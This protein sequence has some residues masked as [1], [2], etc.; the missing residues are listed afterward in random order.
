MSSAPFRIECE[1]ASALCFVDCS[2]R[3]SREKITTE[4]AFKLD[5][6]VSLFSNDGQSKS[7]RVRAAKQRE[8]WH[9]IVQVTKYSMLLLM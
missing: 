3:W 6:R 4:V 5:F 1:V 2:C 8:R 9:K 7:R